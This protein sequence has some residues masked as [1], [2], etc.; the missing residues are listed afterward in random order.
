MCR[1]DKKQLHTFDERICFFYDRMFIREPE[2]NEFSG[3]KRRSSVYSLLQQL[4]SSAITRYFYVYY[5]LKINI[6]LTWK[7]EVIHHS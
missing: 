4:H 1:L 3:G 5:A 6:G 7:T 2:V